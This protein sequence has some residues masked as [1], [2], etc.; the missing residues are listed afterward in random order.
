MVLKDHRG[1]VNEC[2]L[3][4]NVLKHLSDL[5]L[6]VS[7]AND[8]TGKQAAGK[9][10]VRTKGTDGATLRDVF[11]EGIADEGL[12]LHLRQR[13]LE[14]PTCTFYD[15][16]EA[17]LKLYGDDDDDEDVTICGISRHTN[18]ENDSRQQTHREDTG[19]EERA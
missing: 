7:C 13:R 2:L 16:R 10:L 12:K 1:R 9:R 15:V 17:A 14:Q 5:G 3:G 6:P 8:N 11:I 19:V 18:K 4:M